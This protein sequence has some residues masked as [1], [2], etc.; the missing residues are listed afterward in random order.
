MQQL[1]EA[2]HFWRK[3]RSSGTHRA[4]TVGE[5]LPE[6]TTSQATGELDFVFGVFGP[7]SGLCHVPL[8]LNCSV[9]TVA[10]VDSGATCNLMGEDLF[11]SLQ[12]R[13]LKAQLVPSHISLT[14]Y[15]DHPLPVVGEFT[16]TARVRKVAFLTK[17]VV[18]KGKGQLLLGHTDS[19]KFGVLQVPSVSA[20]EA[21]P[22][23]LAS[24]E[25][26]DLYPSVFTGIGKLNDRQVPIHLDPNV[27]PVIQPV[28]RI[29][30]ALQQRVSEKVQELLQADIIEKV[31]E[32]SEWI[33]PVVVVPKISGDIRLCVDL[34]R[35]NEAGLRE[36]YTIP[37]LDD[38]LQKLTGS[39]V[40]S[41]LD[42]KWGFH[43]LELTP[44]SRS[45]TTFIVPDG[46]YRYKRMMFGLASAPEKYQHIIQ[47]L[48]SD[49]PGCLNIAD[50]LIIFGRTGA[51]HDAALHRVL[52]RLQEKGLTV[53]S[54]KCW[55]RRSMVTFFGMCLSAEGVTPMPEK[56]Q[57]VKEAPA[58][59]NAAEVRSFL[60]L[61]GFS[62]RFIKNLATTAEPLR[63]LTRE[64]VP[65]RWGQSQQEAFSELKAQ[66]ASH[67]ALAY[68][69]KDAPT[70]V[71]ADAS[72]VGL[73][74]ML[75]QEQEGVQRV[76]C[77]ASRSLQ[78]VERRYSQHEKEAL[79]GVWACEHF[80][81]YL[82]GKKFTLHTDHQAL[83]VIYGPKSRP[84]ARVERWV[85][86]MQPY[87]F[88]I[89][90]VSGSKMFADALSRL[91][92]PSTAAPQAVLVE[93]S[94]R[95][96]AQVAAPSALSAR[97]IECVSLDD[98]DLKAVRQWLDGCA[99]SVPQDYH[100]VRHELCAIGQLVMRGTR[101]V[102]PKVLRA[103]VL[104]LAHEGHPG[105]VKS[106]ARL[107]NKVWWPRMDSDVER[108]CRTC[109]GCQ[110]VSTPSPAP[111]VIPTELP[112]KA[113]QHLAVDLL[114]PL[115]SSDYLLVLVDYFSRFV[116]VD[117]IRTTSTDTVVSCLRKH[118]ARH[119]L[120]DS[121][122]SDNGP[123]F[124]SAGF[125]N[126]LAEH[127]IQHV[128]TTPYWP[129]ANGEVER[130][131]RSLLK[132]MRIAQ[133]EQKPWKDELLKYL[134]AY[135][136]T[137]HC[138]TGISPAQLLFGRTMRTKLPEVEGPTP[139]EDEMECA[140]RAQDAVAK[141]RMTE[142][143]N[144]H[145]PT[146]DADDILPGATVLVEQFSKS[147]KLA[148]NYQSVPYTVL[149]RHGSQVRLCSTDG[150]RKVIDRNVKHTRLYNTD[151]TSEGQDACTSDPAETD[152]HAVPVVPAGDN[153]TLR[154]SGRECRSSKNDDYVYY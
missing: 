130:Q 17:F 82:F 154:K 52:S 48:L 2:G 23:S 3:C 59:S 146:S 123:Q 98:P 131:N 142:A 64:G 103:Q 89:Q 113:W 114:G 50:D 46:I 31:E 120:P 121:L 70:S 138:S 47:E 94:V 49:L 135:R 108:R 141:E 78:A 96:I 51:D 76:V 129:R 147:D 22:K 41:K 75:V 21:A 65:F 153:A 81:Q 12:S 71:F 95:E 54:S 117:I 84:S 11:S 122:R 8:L 6:N 20:V 73:G 61:V 104:D 29:P 55:F 112:D 26:A 115:P 79:A 38:I 7:V 77:Y 27:P 118:F 92:L 69:D 90:H 37:T 137:P 111:P 66:L 19:T 134:T 139:L 35:A 136:S 63:V 42:L 126:F 150:S 36:R 34:R 39:T 88:T 67:P 110:L 72:P 97:E 128:K 99:P 100:H 62:S 85:L 124:I 152:S 143:A 144:K 44:G 148:T 151:Q 93:E 133:V 10:L 105:I 60:G 125:E 30:F 127:G 9:A 5:K 145:S 53:N 140:A 56:I 83:Q 33:S 101:I 24:D 116:E 57:A 149:E 102:V 43:Q 107:R 87:D 80:N 91:P 1:W 132:A 18:V 86:R 14:A 109:H 106:K 4:N 15:G 13:G 58:P 25:F 32:P 74:A 119:G 40:F 16:A 68:F 45:I 28:R